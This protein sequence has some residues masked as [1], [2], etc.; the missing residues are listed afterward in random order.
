MKLNTGAVFWAVAFV[1]AVSY[2]VCAALV[3]IAPEATSRFFGWVMH[4]DLSSLSHQLTWWSFF[5]GIVWYGLVMGTLASASA[6][7]YNQLVAS[8]SERPG[9]RAAGSNRDGG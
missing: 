6:W 8:P 3:A 1:T 2:I 9:T 7:A 4:I 5:G